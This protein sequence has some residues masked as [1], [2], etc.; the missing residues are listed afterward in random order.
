MGQSTSASP[1]APA[2]TTT[3]PKVTE[4]TAGVEDTISL[5]TRLAEQAPRP[6]SGSRDEGLLRAVL[7][8]SRG[9]NARTA[10]FRVPE[11]NADWDLL[12]WPG[13]LAS[14]L[15]SLP[16]RKTNSW[17]LKSIKCTV[18]S[19]LP[20]P[21]GMNS[22]SLAP[23]E[24]TSLFVGVSVTCI[25]NKGRFDIEIPDSPHCSSALIL[26]RV[27][28]GARLS[29]C[30]IN[31][32]FGKLL[33]PSV[34]TLSAI[35][36][37]HLHLGIEWRKHFSDYC[38]LLNSDKNLQNDD[39]PLIARRTLEHQAIHSFDFSRDLDK[40]YL[41]LSKKSFQDLGDDSLRLQTICG[42]LSG[43]AE[44]VLENI[45][46][47]GPMW[48]SSFVLDQA[49]QIVDAIVLPQMDAI[50]LP[51]VGELST[52]EAV[53]HLLFTQLPQIPN[54]VII[55]FLSTSDLRECSAVCKEWRSALSESQVTLWKNLCLR[56]K[57]DDLFPPQSELLGPNKYKLLYCCACDAVTALSK[58]PTSSEVFK[59]TTQLTYAIRAR[60]VKA[61]YSHLSA[62]RGQLTS[63]SSFP[64]KTSLTLERIINSVNVL[65]FDDDKTSNPQK[66]LATMDSACGKF[67][68]LFE[69]GVR[70][71]SREGE[72]HAKEVTIE[73]LTGFVPK[74][75]ERH[76]LF[77]DGSS[78]SA[79]DTSMF[80]FTGKAK[81]WDDSDS[82]LF[83][84]IPV[85]VVVALTLVLLPADHS[86]TIR[87]FVMHFLRPKTRVNS[88]W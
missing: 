35:K 61:V 20:V 80:G 41:S 5:M 82:M 32:F 81:L 45:C 72:W 86:S 29:D 44:V 76:L 13:D 62:L 52:A 9:A 79:N 84:G 18:K 33:I 4:A 60:G 88:L 26:G 16:E 55:S 71:N 54:E 34:T 14:V 48:L 69:Q 3:V 53:P 87:Q 49:T 50:V 57:W 22:S 12:M 70:E 47:Q 63:A 11:D 78:I 36:R 59:K 67:T 58:E 15:T 75:T 2:P 10:R 21:T 37:S 77:W 66:F 39:K 1:K 30:Q 38:S 7:I 73:Q 19:P 31:G 85:S 64:A 17:V 27:M 28:K 74:S 25:T 56:H 83:G 40:D 43:N 42:L 24:T 68:L 46:T 65:S 51:Q 23:G 8:G 6:T